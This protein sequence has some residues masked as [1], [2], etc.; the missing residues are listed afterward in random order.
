[1]FRSRVRFIDSV[2]NAKIGCHSAVRGSALAALLVAGNFS[3]A[4]LHAEEPEGEWEFMVAPLFLWGMSIDGGSDNNAWH[5]NAMADYR[6]NDWGSA[7]VGY[8]YMK[9]DYAS[10][11]YSY[12]AKQQGPLLGVS[13]Y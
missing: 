2:A 11:S 8:R 3:S 5:F 10:S 7:F 9:I 13:I 4:Q 12:D 1:M 6:F